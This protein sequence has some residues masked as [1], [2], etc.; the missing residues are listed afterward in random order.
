MIYF[1]NILSKLLSPWNSQT[2]LIQW[3]RNGGHKPR[4]IAISGWYAIFHEF[5]IKA[6]IIRSIRIDNVIHVNC[7]I[8][9]SG[10][11]KEENSIGI[12]HKISN[13][14]ILFRMTE[15]ESMYNKNSVNKFAIISIFFVHKKEEWRELH[16][17]SE[18]RNEKVFHKKY[19]H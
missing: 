14:W 7:P 6:I 9:L 17:N 11:K 13:E 16:R 1:Y 18:K 19:H 10:E 2:S 5:N 15:I 12:L 4:K 8:H 3:I